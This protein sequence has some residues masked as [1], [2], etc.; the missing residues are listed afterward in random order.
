MATI[1]V[2]STAW[3]MFRMKVL[4]EE[5][6]V[7]FDAP[8]ETNSEEAEVEEV[9][10]NLIAPYATKQDANVIRH[11]PSAISQDIR[12]ENL[13]NV[14]MASDCHPESKECSLMYEENSKRKK[15][16]SKKN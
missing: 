8:D 11:N 10:E 4:S 9:R 12:G 13:S 6:E 2:I 15:M 14:D 16:F 1:S 7:F 5:L 3:K